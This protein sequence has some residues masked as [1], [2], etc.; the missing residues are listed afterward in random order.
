MV[1]I[2]NLILAVLL[3]IGTGTLSWSQVNYEGPEHRL[4]SHSAT[5]VGSYLFIIGGHDGAAY[6]ADL[7]Y[8]NLGA[9][10]SSQGY[11]ITNT[12]FPVS[13]QWES[14]PSFG[15]SP[16]LRGYH[17]TIVTDSRLFVF[18][19]FNGHE[20]HDDVH[21]LDLAGT[22]YLPQVMSFQIDV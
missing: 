22:A 6:S 20:V 17:A 10:Y 1:S 7:L 19:G 2:G 15:R 12:C 13:L 9:F 5:Q 8:F 16:S 4:L 11:L 18:G 3:I 21:V 14:R